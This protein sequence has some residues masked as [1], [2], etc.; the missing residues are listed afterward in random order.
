MQLEATERRMTAG[1]VLGHAGEV[2]KDQKPA[3][4]SRLHGNHGRVDPL[5]GRRSVVP[6]T[7][8]RLIVLLVLL[9]SSASTAIAADK[10]SLVARW[11]FGTEESVSFSAIGNVQ[12]DQAG[13]R[14]PEFPELAENN[15]AVRL[16]A[17][18]YLA[19]PDT[20]SGS[21][22]D[23]EN[24]D[25]ITIEAWVNPSELR[26]GQVSYVVGKGRTGSPK[27]ARDNQ[28]WSLRVIGAKREARLSFLF[29]KI[30]RAHV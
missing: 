28:N 1:L 20:G 8:G 26:D 30:G 7:S 16:D 12:R 3:A 13:P 6:K 29:A 14:P 22:F 5:P 9:V 24:G 25:A 2:Q 27:F 21:D 4:G 11:E 15:T 10:A 18:A 17:A 19:V 23:F